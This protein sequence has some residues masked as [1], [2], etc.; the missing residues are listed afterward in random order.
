MNDTILNSEDQFVKKCLFCGRDFQELSKEHIIPNAICGRIKSKNL[1]CKDCNSTL[2][3]EIDNGL[4]GVYSQIINMFNIKRERGE[5]EPVVV[6]SVDDEKKYK[7]FSNGDY[8]FAESYVKID[9]NENNQLTIA[10]EG[11]VDKEKLKGD[12]GKFFRSNEKKLKENGYDF[13]K[14]IKYV[15]DEIDKNWIQISNN[16]IQFKPNLIKF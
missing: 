16:K 1:I 6:T 12:I 13:K 7:Y 3:Q 8:E 11:P 9:F 4:D 14:V 2:G 15:Q 10:I 5:S